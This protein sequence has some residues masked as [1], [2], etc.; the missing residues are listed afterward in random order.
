[1]VNVA[2][3]DVIGGL[4]K[5]DPDE[6]LTI[7]E[8][9]QSGWVSVCLHA[10]D[11]LPQRLLAAVVM[12]LLGYYSELSFKYWILVI[13]SPFNYQNLYLVKSYHSLIALILRV[14]F[15]YVVVFYALL[16]LLRTFKALNG[17]LCADVPLRN[18]SLTHSNCT[19]CFIARVWFNYLTYKHVTE[20][21]FLRESL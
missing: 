4:L 6:R 1:M 8:V 7:R 14:I 15:I 10:S 20:V 11:Y 3:K 16:F 9:M 17:L 18:Y 2:A 21:G 13:S 19:R 5:T 12:V